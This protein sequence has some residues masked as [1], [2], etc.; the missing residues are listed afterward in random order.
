MPGNL[1]ATCPGAA[2][3]PARTLL[4]AVG[5]GAVSETGDD[6]ANGAYVNPRTHASSSAGS[7]SLFPSVTS[8]S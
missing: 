2:H 8:T 7:P 5:V 3:Q 6:P 1:Q 4:A